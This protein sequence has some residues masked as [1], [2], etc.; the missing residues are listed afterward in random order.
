[1]ENNGKILIADDEEPIR[2]LVE[3][4][5]NRSGYNNVET[6]ENGLLAHNAIKSG[7]INPDLIITDYNYKIPEMNGLDF[8]K[9]YAPKIPC[10]MMTANKEEVEQKALDLGAKVVLGKPF[11]LKELT[12]AVDKHIK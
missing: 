10:I 3:M 8:L 4:M 7:E 6:Y 2:T 1:M 5:L 11:K 9:I 12:D